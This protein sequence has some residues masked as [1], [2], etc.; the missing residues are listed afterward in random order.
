MES[1]FK[2][3]L[4]S[5]QRA[6]GEELYSKVLSDSFTPRS[7][8]P[9]AAAASTPPPSELWSGQLNAPHTPVVLIAAVD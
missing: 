2:S 6:A 9:P 1:I 5:V 4:G 3:G 8:R 7:P